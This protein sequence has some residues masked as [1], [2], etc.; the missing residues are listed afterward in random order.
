MDLNNDIIQSVCPVQY[1][2]PYQLRPINKV[3]IYKH[4]I[5]QITQYGIS[6][7]TVAGFWRLQGL[8]GA[9][10]AIG[11][12]QRNLL[13]MRRLGLVTIVCVC[14]YCGVCWR[15]RSQE[16]TLAW[17]SVR[18]LYSNLST[19]KR[20][21]I[22]YSYVFVWIYAIVE[23]VRGKSIYIYIY[24]S[25]LGGGGRDVCLVAIASTAL[26]VDDLHLR[27][28]R[29]TFNTYN[30]FY[31]Q[32]LMDLYTNPLHSLLVFVCVSFTLPRGDERE[33]AYW[34]WNTCF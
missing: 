1:G 19:I 22:V 8:C 34:W 25:T 11:Q 28:P 2:V 15:R 14:M 20:A 30:Q 27:H 4:K 9:V 7:N 26:V 13:N 5:G 33:I 23:S 21:L 10:Q 3:Y 24:I 16:F 31:A 32:P 12:L 29:L 6:S 17:R 18:Q